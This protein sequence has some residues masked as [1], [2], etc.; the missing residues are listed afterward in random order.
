MTR[1]SGNMGD[2]CRCKEQRSMRNREQVFGFRPPTVLE[3]RL[4]HAN[5][6]VAYNKHRSRPTKMDQVL[7]TLPSHN[8]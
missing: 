5:I 2:R 8:N 3:I 1:V 4:E 6:N 7:T